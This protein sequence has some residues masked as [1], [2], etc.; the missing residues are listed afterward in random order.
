MKKSTFSNSQI[1]LQLFI[2]LPFIVSIPLLINVLETQKNIS[3]LPPFNINF[4]VVIITFLIYMIIVVVLAKWKKIDMGIAKL[5]KVK[6]GFILLSA[7]LVLFLSIFLI[8]MSLKMNINYW[9]R[10]ESKEYIQILVESKHISNGRGTDYYVVFSSKNGG[11]TNKV[12]HK[13]Y[14]NFKIGE[15]FNISVNQGYFEGFYLTEEIK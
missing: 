7:T 4:S 6:R 12:T 5:K 1:L 14:D 15:S 11:L 13:T 2:V 3:L 10:S 9:W 8:V